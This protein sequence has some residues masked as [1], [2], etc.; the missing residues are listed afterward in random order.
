[1]NL[2]SLSFVV[3][4]AEEWQRVKNFQ[5]EILKEI[6]GL[7]VKAPSGTNCIPLRNIT[8]LEFMAAVRIKRTKF[9]ELVQE[10]KVRVI[11]KGRKIYVPVEEVERYFGEG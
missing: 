8:A 4:P 6:K 3:I 2:D 11:R 7:Q 5:E 10:N 1:M 9:D